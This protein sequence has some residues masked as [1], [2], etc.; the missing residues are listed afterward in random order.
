MTI[1]YRQLSEGLCY[2]LD[3][4]TVLDVT[5]LFNYYKEES[6]KNG[7]TE[8][9]ALVVL[10]QVGLEILCT[11]KNIMNGLNGVVFSDLPE[12]SFSRELKRIE[13]R[14][15]IMGDG[16]DY[17]DVNPLNELFEV[18]PSSPLYPYIVSDKH[19]VLIRGWD[20]DG[21]NMSITIQVI[22]V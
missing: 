22:D 16:F 9:D 2:G 3:R 12:D 21:Y 19:M 18:I 5:K 4:C 7:L 13:F 6:N 8:D 1:T 10:F 15:R 11:S 20:V 17:R 14:S